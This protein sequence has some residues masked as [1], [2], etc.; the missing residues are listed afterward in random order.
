MNKKTIN[1]YVNRVNIYVNRYFVID[2]N[3]KYNC[4]Q[5]A[6]YDINTGKF[7]EG[8]IVLCGIKNNPYGKGWLM[9]SQEALKLIAR[10]KEI[11]GETFRVFLYVVGILDFE[12]WIYI[13][14]KEIAEYLELKRSAVSRSIKVLLEKE[15]ILKGERFGKSYTFRLNPYF[16]WKGRVK[17]LEEYREEKEKERIE[18][19]KNTTDRRKNKNLEEF[20]KKT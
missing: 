14:Q 10:D 4:L 17:S 7:L 15:I 13:P 9:T 18:E 11:T 20:S 12:N 3:M 2:K 6:N 1:I 5:V 16:G 8:V 19:L